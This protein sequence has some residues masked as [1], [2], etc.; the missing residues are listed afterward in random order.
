MNLKMDVYVCF[1]QNYFGLIDAD[2]VVEELRI[3]TDQMKID[4]WIKEK[5]AEGKEAGY[6]PE[7]NPNDF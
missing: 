5:V 1:L 3:E 6:I 7:E 4:E 2:D